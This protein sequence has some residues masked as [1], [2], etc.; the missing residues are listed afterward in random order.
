MKHAARG[1]RRFLCLFW[2]TEERKGECI[3]D[4]F[5]SKSF[6]NFPLFSRKEKEK[7]K[8]CEMK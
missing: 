2:V 1:Q 8:E 6:T 7:G 5:F 4:L 3:K